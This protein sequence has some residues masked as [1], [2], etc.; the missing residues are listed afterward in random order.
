MVV[1]RRNNRTVTMDVVGVVM[2]GARRG[3][4][5]MMVSAKCTIHDKSKRRDDRQSG[6]KTP[7]QR[8]EGLNH[9]S[10]GSRRM[11]KTLIVGR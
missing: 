1:V 4:R 8:V 6:R 7:D 2:T 5:S 3:H 9:P 11:H 10:T